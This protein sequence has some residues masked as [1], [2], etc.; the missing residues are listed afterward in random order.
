[1]W[2]GSSPSAVVNGA[3]G[4]IIAALVVAALYVGRDPLH[5]PR[6]GGTAGVLASLFAG[7]TVVGR[8]ITHRRSRC[9]G[10]YTP[11]RCLHSREKFALSFESGSPKPP[12]CGEG[13]VVGDR[14]YQ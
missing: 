6:P 2:P 8:Q 11:R 10:R 13:C 12:T 3:A 1:M 4:M 5:A 7:A 9:D 14:L